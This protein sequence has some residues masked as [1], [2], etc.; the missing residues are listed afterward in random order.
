MYVIPNCVNN[1][2]LV[3]KMD[4][5]VSEII[6]CGLMQFFAFYRLFAPCLYYTAG[7]FGLSNEKGVRRKTIAPL[8]GLKSLAKVYFFFLPFAAVFL[9]LCLTAAWAAASRAIGTRN[10]EQLT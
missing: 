3:D 8:K 10:G 7:V 1:Q 4:M 9:G 5:G 2:P 6:F